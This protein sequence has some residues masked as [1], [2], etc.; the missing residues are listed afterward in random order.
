MREIYIMARN[1]K[2]FVIYVIV[3][4][5]ALVNAGVAGAFAPT[6]AGVRLLEAPISATVQGFDLEIL[7]QENSQADT[8]IVFCDGLCVVTTVPCGAACPLMGPATATANGLSLY[9]LLKF[10]LTARLYTGLE[11]NLDP[12]PPKTG[13]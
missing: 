5:T 2:Q 3:I 8:G 12:H 13:A 10:P 7:N 4:V 6:E 9:S 1:L 11:H